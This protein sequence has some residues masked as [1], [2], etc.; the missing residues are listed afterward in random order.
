MVI[1]STKLLILILFIFGYSL[2]I[3]QQSINKIEN[4]L[5]LNTFIGYGTEN[6]WGNTAFFGGATLSKSVNKHL[7]LEGGVTLFTTAFYNV[8]KDRPTG[9]VGQD[10]Y[11]HAVFL[12]PDVNYTF[13]NRKSFLNASIKV[14]SSLKYQKDKILKFYLE[15]VYPDG[16]IEVVP[17]SVQYYYEKGFNISYYAG[18]SF[19]AK[20]NEKLRFGIFLDTY[21]HA[22][23][24][25]HFMPGINAIF[26]L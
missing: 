16:R 23:A 14:G 19:D 3:A 10:R 22:I 2:A 11:Y 12:T 6:N 25:E 26:K 21:L 5:Y 9:L 15:H 4:N 20:V 24:I 8:Y 13:G 17:E 7:F 1:T 18:V